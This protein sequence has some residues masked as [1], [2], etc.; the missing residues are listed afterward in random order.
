MDDLIGRIQQALRDFHLSAWLFYGFQDLDPIAT[1]ILQFEPHLLA[2][3]R[4]FY[5]IPEKGEP[6]KLVHRIESSI[7]DH[8]PGSKEIYL[9]WEQLQKKVKGLL[10]GV[11]AVAMQYSE[12]NSIP[13]ISLVDAGTIDLVRGCGTQVVSSGDLIQR[14]EAVWSPHQV[15]Q[16]RATALALTSI[17]QAAFEQ[18]AT[19]IS[20]QGDTDE[21]S[22]QR[23][24]LDRFE[25]EDL[26]TAHPPIVA[27]NENSANPHYQPTEAGYSKIGSDDFLLIDLWAKSKKENSVYADIT[28]TGLMSKQVPEKHSEI[29]QVVRQARD[30]G[31]DFLR[32]RFEGNNLPQGWEVDKVVRES[33][34]QAGYAEFFVHRTGHNLGRE[35]HGNGVH[36]DNL[37][38]HD[39]R[40]VIPGIACTIEPG[41]Y[42][43]GKFGVRSE[44]N[45][46]FSQDGPEITT[47]PQEKIWKLGSA[48]RAQKI[49]NRK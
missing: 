8:L 27:V 40:L 33:I 23:F 15:E 41:I 43:E 11:S 47:P 16:H 45:V 28:W 34:R 36:F 29:F 49:E 22:I 9:E 24:I 12:N 46:F 30:Q 10:G 17:V 25:K 44:I 35:V 1:R 26:L 20:S 4:W 6:S 18:V 38:T 2:T 14:F 42:L 13:Y 31:V 32:E 5:L 39:T 7:L 19:E 3:R 21:L 37:E 48:L